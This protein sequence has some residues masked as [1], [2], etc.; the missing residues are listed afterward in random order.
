MARPFSEPKHSA[1]HPQ[2]LE[3]H[4]INTKAEHTTGVRSQIT[5]TLHADA[6]VGDEISRTVR[7]K[8]MISST[9]VFKEVESSRGHP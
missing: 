4:N 3:E 6:H 2:E 5:V 1:H 8:P 7:A 9:A